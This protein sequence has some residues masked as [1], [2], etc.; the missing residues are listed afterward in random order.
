MASN[1][2]VLARM[3]M[4]GAIRVARRA[5]QSAPEIVA[6]EALREAIDEQVTLASNLA[7]RCLTDTIDYANAK[8]KVARWGAAWRGS[9]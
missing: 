2:R 9:R 8:D 4:L 7:W 5:P 6:M 3:R 1:Q